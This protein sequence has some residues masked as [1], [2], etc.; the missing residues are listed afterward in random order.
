MNRAAAPGLKAVALHAGVSVA[1]VSRVINDGPYV[2][3]ALRA[4]VTA[5]MAAVGYVPN[6]PAKSLRTG[7]TMTVGYVVGD[8][9]N[10]LFATIARGID[11]ELQRSDYT[12]FLGNSRG[13]AGHE[14][15]LIQH[16]LRRRVD[17]LILSLADE[18]DTAL[19]TLLG[20]LS[21]PLVLLDRDL[22]DARADRV[23]VDHAG[24][25]AAA[26]GHLVALGHR[27]IALITGRPTTRPGMA[28]REGFDRAAAAHGL[29]VAP[30]HRK[31][32]P[33]SDGFGAVA[34]G[35]LLDEPDPPTAVIAGGAQI[36]PGVLRAARARGLRIPADLSL[37]AYDDTDVTA[38]YDPA[39]TVVARDVYAIGAEA[40]RLLLDRLTARGEPARRRTVTIPTTLV[41]RGSTAR[42]RARG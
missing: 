42:P 25:I 27:R 13:E 6:T 24:G 12:M 4:R 14:L 1:T 10:P 8:I 23:L 22:G 9:A 28:I 34:L 32:G 39:I 33:F 40:A 18:T 17:G 36:T 31:V 16:M 15:Q 5:S 19:Q 29:T 41:V 26:L 7:Q 35:A 30:H 21:L 2:T 3:E 37:I 11:D 20:G 38:L